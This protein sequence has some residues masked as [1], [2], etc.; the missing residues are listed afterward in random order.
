[1]SLAVVIPAKA[2]IQKA[3]TF[4]SINYFWALMKDA[5]LLYIYLDD[6]FK[7]QVLKE[8]YNIES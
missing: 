3:R 4:K 6:L 2:G 7:C 5:V 1:M 8:K